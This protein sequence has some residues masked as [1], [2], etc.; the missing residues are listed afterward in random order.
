MKLK[1]R[2]WNGE[3]MVSPDYIDREGIA[4]WK[5]NSIPTMSKNVMV[6]TGLLDKQ[7]KEIYEGDIVEPVSNADIK[8]EVVWNNYRC[9]FWLVNK[10]GRKES[11]KRNLVSD[12][13]WILELFIEPFER[14]VIGNIYENPELL[15]TK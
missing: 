6:W 2:C 3:E 9:G 8:Y 10:H 1:F 11:I 12:D 5:E 4:W 7:G 15:E 13:W 14:V